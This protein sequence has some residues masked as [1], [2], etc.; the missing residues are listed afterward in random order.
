MKSKIMMNAPLQVS[1]SRKPLTNP[2]NA[3]LPE[4]EFSNIKT[5]EKD[6][7]NPEQPQQIV[8]EL[9]NALVSE[10]SPEEKKSDV[11]N[12]VEEKQSDT[13]SLKTSIAVS[14]QAEQEEAPP[15][16]DENQPIA[17]EQEI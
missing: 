17:N 11:K 8:N 6:I 16:I 5:D 2:L 9:P 10:D 3:P 15:K 7:S 1:T 12:G 14:E 13:D 4:V